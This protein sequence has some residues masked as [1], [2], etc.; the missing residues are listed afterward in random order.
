MSDH[1]PKVPE[2]DEEGAFD[3]W[4]PAKCKHR[5]HLR[6][7]QDENSILLRTN[8]NLV[9]LVADLTTRLFAAQQY[10]DNGRVPHD[11]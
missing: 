6:R 5:K 10:S 7:I 4:E 2:V 1:D 8:E 9:G 3:C 11:V